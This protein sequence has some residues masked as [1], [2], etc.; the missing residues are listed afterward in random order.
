MSVWQLSVCTVHGMG[1]VPVGEKQAGVVGYQQFT[2]SGTREITPD[3][4]NYRVWVRLSLVDQRPA[5]R[6]DK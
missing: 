1:I 3:L 2:E 4:G 6:T 5:K